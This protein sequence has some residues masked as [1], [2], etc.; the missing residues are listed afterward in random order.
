MAEV[1]V[2]Q[3]QQIINQWMH[4]INH[5][6]DGKQYEIVNEIKN[7]MINEISIDN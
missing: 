6:M 5:K 2:D 3:S 7:T 1:M 4:I